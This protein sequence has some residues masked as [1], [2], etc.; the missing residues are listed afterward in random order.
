MKKILIAVLTVVALACCFSA[1]NNKPSGN[2]SAEINP[3][4]FASE[5]LSIE[6]FKEMQL[7]Y[8]VKGVITEEIKFSSSNTAVVTVNDNGKIVAVKEGSAVVT[9]SAGNAFDTLNV[10]VTPCDKS[11]LELFY[12]LDSL[13]I[14]ETYSKEIKP[15]VLYDGAEVDGGEFVYALSNENV[16]LS[17]NT[18]TGQSKGN[19][20]LT[21]SGSIREIALNSLTVQL[22]VYEKLEIL[23]GDDVADENEIFVFSGSQ[24][25][26]AITEL[27]FNPSVYLNDNLV[28]SANVTIDNSNSSV[29]EIVDGKVKAK[30]VGSANITISYVSEKDTEIS[31]DVA[32]RIQDTGI[33][34]VDLKINDKK[35][36]VIGNGTVNIYNALPDVDLSKVGY[37]SFVIS[38]Y[39]FS[40][41]Y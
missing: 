3:L 2:P 14:Y 1:C 27:A 38:Y 25:Q 30:G 20:T 40:C 28:D 26:N 7:D 36:R 10:M 12:E 18:I 8:D 33:N 32:R 11:K 13:N 6:M 4:E 19:S 41:I 35:V 16:S 5:T 39:T 31:E 29:I 34:I 23:F 37:Q 22:N 9:M 15:I 24:E 21:I 17:E